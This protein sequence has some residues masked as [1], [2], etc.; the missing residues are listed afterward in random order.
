MLC[1]MWRMIVLLDTTIPVDSMTQ[2]L[3]HA[4]KITCAGVRR[5]HGFGVVFT[6]PVAYKRTSLAVER[7]PWKHLIVLSTP[8][9]LLMTTKYME[10]MSPTRWLKRTIIPERTTLP[11]RLWGQ[12]STHQVSLNNGIVL[13]VFVELVGYDGLWGWFRNHV[14]FVLL[15][16]SLVLTS[17]VRLVFEYSS[18]I[19]NSLRT[20]TFLPLGRCMKS[21]LVCKNLHPILYLIVTFW[22]FHIVRNV[23]GLNRIDYCA[24]FSSR[25]PRCSMRR[26]VHYLIVVWILSEPSLCHSHINDPFCPIIQAIR[27]SIFWERFRIARNIPLS[28]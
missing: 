26:T 3:S 20:F 12:L 17:L 28:P 4:R 14:S 2:V 21:L 6:P 1:L 5:M 13:L 16:D 10:K 9:S 15:W 27:T 24:L 11:N 7:K 19:S 18:I 25:D 22:K 8:S 23:E